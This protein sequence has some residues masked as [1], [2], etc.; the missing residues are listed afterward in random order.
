M[1]GRESFAGFGVTQNNYYWYWQRVKPS[2]NP[3]RITPLIN[4][5]SNSITVTLFLAIVAAVIDGNG[6]HLTSVHENSG[7]PAE[8]LVTPEETTDLAEK[9]DEKPL[10]DPCLHLNIEKLNSLW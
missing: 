8:P 7:H 2:S 5:M 10:E 6:H 3:D 9:Q 1:A 4:S